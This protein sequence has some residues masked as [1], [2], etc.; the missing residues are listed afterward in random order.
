[1]D[2]VSNCPYEKF[3]ITVQ[4]FLNKPYLPYSVGFSLIEQFLVEFTLSSK[5]VIAPWIIDM[6]KVRYTLIT[7]RKLSSKYSEFVPQFGI[8]IM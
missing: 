1:M 4:F 7:G 6:F 3:Y 5:F 8:L 2:F